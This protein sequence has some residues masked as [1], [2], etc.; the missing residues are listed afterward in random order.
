MSLSFVSIILSVIFWVLGILYLIE[1]KYSA[2]V[3]IIIGIVSI[4]LSSNYYKKYW[5]ID[6]K[7]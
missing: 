4:V 3:Y 2:I 5:L 6:H 1:K 7:Q